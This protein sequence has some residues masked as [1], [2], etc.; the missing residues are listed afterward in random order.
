[1]VNSICL[2]LRCAS[3]LDFV[4]ELQQMSHEFRLRTAGV[5]H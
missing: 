5:S 4:E 2:A 1:M 3:G